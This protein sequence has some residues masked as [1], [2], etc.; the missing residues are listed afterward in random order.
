MATG[1]ICF[2]AWLVP[3]GGHLLLR[4]WGRGL[5]FLFLVT[6]LFFTGLTLQGQLFGWAPGLFGFLKFFAN[7]SLGFL[8][9]LGS[10]TGWGEGDLRAATYEYGNTFLYTAGLLNMLIIVDA[11]DIAVGRKQ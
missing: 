6:L 8:Y 4:K 10:F 9:L 1:M 5:I 2:M 3:G 7:A 11:F